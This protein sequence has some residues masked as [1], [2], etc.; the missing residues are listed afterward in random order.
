LF[1]NT[2]NICLV[3]LVA[4]LV[5]GALAVPAPT[6]GADPISDKEAQAKQLQDEI[7]ATNEQLSALGERYN[8]AQL[9]LEQTE[10][11]LTEIEA[12]IAATQAEVDRTLGLVHER[13]ASVYRRALTGKSLEDLDYSDSK[14][15]VLRKH[16][17]SVQ[18]RRDDQLLQQLDDAK[19]TLAD[20]RAVAERA[21]ETAEQERREI[22]QMKTE[23]EAKSD[24]QR[25]LLDQV[26]GELEQLVAAEM[27]RRQAEAAAMAAGKLSGGDG[28]PNLPP[29]GPAAAQALAYAEA[30]IGKTYVYAADGPDHFDCSG[31]TMAAYRSAGVSLPH[32]SG[33]QYAALPHVPLDHVM[34]GDLIFWGT[35]ASTHVALYYGN[36]R[37]LESGGS[38]HD[39]HIG[40]IW[41]HPMG[42]ARVLR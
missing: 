34:P 42:A 23:L 35:N 38:G 15:L 27:A 39:V 25:R 18:A 20:Q 1:R 3:A 7:E 13:S 37:I 41:G 17:A 32:Y 4:V 40:P 6:A 10:A 19:D 36:A 8:G 11:E 9:R 29:P 33:A 2:R 22:E 14:D 30:Q 12:K 24:E 26:Q 31:L 16:Y 5:A 21:R 28:D